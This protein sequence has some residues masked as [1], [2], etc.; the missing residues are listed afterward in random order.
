MHPAQ[1]IV[2][3][4]SFVSLDAGTLCLSATAAALVILGTPR[5]RGP[6]LAASIGWAA[7]A[8]IADA[9]EAVTRV[10]STGGP[11]EVILEDPLR[12]ALAIGLTLG[13]AGILVLGRYRVAAATMALV[14]LPVALALQSYWVTAAPIGSPA[15][16][17]LVDVPVVGSLA[18]VFV[19]SRRRAD[20]AIGGAAPAAPTAHSRRGTVL[21]V[22]IAP[23]LVLGG[24]AIA[25]TASGLDWAN[26]AGVN[27][28]QYWQLSASGPWGDW[29]RHPDASLTYRL[30]GGA[31]C[32]LRAVITDLTTTASPTRAAVS[33]RDFLRAGQYRGT[34][35]ADADVAR[36]IRSN[37]SA[38]NEMTN[39]WGVPVRYGRG[40]GNDDPDVDYFEAV[41]A[42][43]RRA[44]VDHVSRTGGD[45]EDIAI[46]SMTRCV[47]TLR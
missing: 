30:P 23:A 20:V 11:I 27:W 33:A 17:L 12:T 24:S 45:P 15:T 36:A 9:Y 40:T 34:L 25:L 26:P 29:A 10:G 22:A 7:L 31:S 3:P 47:G 2:A 6:L 16:P 37:P 21:A 19:T 28:R 32:T 5:T 8:C 46:I 35:L 18:A 39:F 43:L 14:V 41:D 44:V 1:T 4:P 38:Q 42:G 13:V